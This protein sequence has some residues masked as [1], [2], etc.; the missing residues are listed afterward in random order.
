MSEQDNLNQN[1][2]SP[3]FGKEMSMTD[4]AINGTLEGLKALY[5]NRAERKRNPKPSPSLE[6]IKVLAQYMH[7]RSLRKGYPK[8]LG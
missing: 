6:R 8:H 1:H 2:P 3:G 5:K 4:I 7:D